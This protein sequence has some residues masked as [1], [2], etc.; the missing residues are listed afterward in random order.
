MS[1]SGV[2]VF[3][4]VTQRNADELSE[5]SSASQNKLFQDSSPRNDTRQ[6]TTIHPTLKNLTV[7][8]LVT[9]CMSLNLLAFVC[10]LPAIYYTFCAAVS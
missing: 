9:S 6:P 10:V 3:L 1:S 5:K 8:S 7:V 2:Q 4:H